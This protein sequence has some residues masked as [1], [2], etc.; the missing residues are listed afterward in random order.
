MNKTVYFF[1]TLFLSS[2]FIIHTVSSDAGQ[3]QEYN[4]STKKSRKRLRAKRLESAAPVLE[5]QEA[6]KIVMLDQT[7]QPQVLHFQSNTLLPQTAKD[8]KLCMFLNRLEFTHDGIAA[9]FSQ[10]FNQREYATQFLPHNFTHLTQFMNYGEQ[11][12]QSLEF[13]DGVLRLFCTKL[14]GASFVNN[15]A[16]EQFLARSIPSYEKLLPQEELSL[17]KDIKKLLWTNFKD[18]FSF[19]TSSPMLFFEDIS[20]QIVKKVK[21]HVSNPDHFRA[22]LIRFTGTAIDKLAWAPE[23][24]LGT[25]NSFKA[26]GQH[27]QTMYQK[28]IINDTFD[29]NELYWG[30]IERYCFFLE[31]AGSKLDLSVCESI[32]NDLKTGTLSWLQL[33][34][35]EPGLETKTERLIQAVMET[36]AKI[37]VKQHGIVTELIPVY[38][39]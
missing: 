34:E 11:T 20:D 16:F 32:K 10:I 19:L 1:I 25:W 8:K 26:T 3:M 2:C 35:Q 17:W 29:C 33:E 14:K 12:N 21:L 27:L 24:Q 15:N 30:L 28:G 36:E 7:C 38:K 5:K 31:L 39:N 23:D 22:T 18:K 6:E 4:K 9:F 37:R 13:F